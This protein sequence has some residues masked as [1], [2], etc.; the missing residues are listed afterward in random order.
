MRLPKLRIRKQNSIKA[1]LSLE[2]M[3]SDKVD[4]ESRITFVSVKK[5]NHPR[6]TYLEKVSFKN[7]GDFQ[8]S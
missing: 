4:S 5:N 3:E 6:T 8:L 7:K 1:D 2:V